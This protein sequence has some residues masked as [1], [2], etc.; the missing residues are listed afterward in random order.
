MSRASVAAYHDQPQFGGRSPDTVYF[1]D[2]RF[3]RLRFLVTVDY[4]EELRM[5]GT[6]F[7]NRGL[8]SA[9]G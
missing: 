7:V 9:S 4:L 1:R 5:I 6:R 3:I 8:R 2:V